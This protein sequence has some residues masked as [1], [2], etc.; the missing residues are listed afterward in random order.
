MSRLILLLVAAVLFASAASGADWG[1]ERPIAI[2]AGS[3]QEQP[4][5]DGHIIAWADNRSG[6]YDIFMY[7]LET[8]LERWA[9]VNPFLQVHPAVSGERIVWQDMRSG[10]ADIYM[11]D[12][13]SRTESVVSNSAGNKT[14]PS[15]SGD[16]VVW[17]DDRNGNSN[18][19]M[20]DLAAKKEKR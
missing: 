12:A 4:A 5:I 18:I 2:V 6:N 14:Q 11:Y 19:Y 15:I 10:K 1:K 16:R 20:Y 9:C 7:D 3:E 17:S 8:G 13:V